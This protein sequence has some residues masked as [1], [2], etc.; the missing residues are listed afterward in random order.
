MQPLAPGAT[1]RSAVFEAAAA[2]DAAA[3][4]AA[5]VDNTPDKAL[6]VLRG[7]GGT[8]RVGDGV[9]ALKVAGVYF[10]HRDGPGRRRLNGSEPL[11]TQRHQTRDKGWRFQVGG[12]VNCLCF[13]TTRS[14]SMCLAIVN[15][16]VSNNIGALFEILCF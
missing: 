3:A 7:G 16:W 11:M 6:A 2:A 9:A 10:F 4:A 5:A 1:L 13:D 14:D 12:G 8:V 15:S